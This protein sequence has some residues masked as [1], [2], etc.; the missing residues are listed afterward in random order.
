MADNA[1]KLLLVKQR[2]DMMPGITARDDYLEMRIKAA[3]GELAKMGIALDDSAEDLL[4][5]VDYTVWSF[6]NR[7]KTGTRPDWLTRRI[8]ERWLKGGAKA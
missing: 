7:D 6:Q 4:L 5:L 3:E 1:Q 2:L 8:R